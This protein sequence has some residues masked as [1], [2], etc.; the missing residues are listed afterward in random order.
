MGW[1]ARARR[2]AFTLVARR[3]RQSRCAIDRHRARQDHG[4]SGASPAG[5]RAARVRVRSQRTRRDRHAPVRR[6][7]PRVVAVRGARPAP[8]ACDAVRAPDLE[9]GG[10]RP[11]RHARGTRDTASADRE[12]IGRTAAAVASGLAS[13]D[14]A[15]RLDA[16]FASARYHDHV[17]DR[18]DEAL[19]R[20]AA[21][22]DEN[23]Y[24]MLGVAPS[25][26]TETIH[27]AYLEQAARWHPDRAPVTSRRCVSSTSACSR[28]SAKRRTR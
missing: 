17:R 16:P 25:A 10:D 15:A 23:F 7:A 14:S 11:T 26:S 12:R 28:T 4:A 21:M 22:E 5:S 27:A 2:R 3:A 1:F 13:V 6:C 18:Y 20:L 8:R 9:A 19:A 24:Q